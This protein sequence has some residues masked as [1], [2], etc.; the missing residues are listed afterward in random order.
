MVSAGVQAR[1]VLGYWVKRGKKEQLL[2]EKLE[3]LHKHDI[4][5]GAMTQLG[6][7]GPEGM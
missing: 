2:I 4:V 6:R 5:L 3:D 7:T 1:N